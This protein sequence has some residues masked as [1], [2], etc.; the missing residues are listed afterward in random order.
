ML[1]KKFKSS[2]R[3]NFE[4]YFGEMIYFGSASLQSE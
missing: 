1:A 2:F 4:K 3:N